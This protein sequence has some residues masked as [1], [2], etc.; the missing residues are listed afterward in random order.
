VYEGHFGLKEKPFSLLPDPRFF[1]ASRTH[2]MGYTMLRYALS[3]QAAIV[4]LT[5]EVGTGKT[6]LVQHLLEEAGRRLLVGVLSSTHAA[7]GALTTHVLRAFNLPRQQGG[8][9]VHL[10]SFC[11]FLLNTRADGRRAVLIVDEA[12]NLDADTLEQLRLLSNLNN[13][14]EPLLQLVL[15]GQP[16]LRR[17][18]QQPD[19]RQFVQRV[20]L[21]H[22]LHPLGIADTLALIRHRLQVAGA[23]CD[24]FEYEAVVAIQ[25]FSQGLPRLINMLGDMALLRAFLDEA[26]TIGFDTVMDVVEERHRADGLTAFRSLPRDVTRSLLRQRLVTDA[27]ADAAN[28]I[29]PRWIRGADG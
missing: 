10:D 23:A 1:Y 25:Y 3:E 6:T 5:G 2:D 14:P 4:V 13:E 28:V 22:H 27:A 9:D 24:I 26:T 20:A 21:H 12:Q 15:V 11:E 8:S 16:E 19:L 18:L 7:F 29:A 17:T